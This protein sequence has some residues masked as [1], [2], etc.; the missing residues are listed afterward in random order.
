MAV[1]ARRVWPNALLYSSAVRRGVTTGCLEDMFGL[2]GSVP[3]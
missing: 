2:C 1:T 3:T